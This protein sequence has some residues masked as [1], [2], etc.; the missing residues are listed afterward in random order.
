MNRFKIISLIAGLA[1]VLAL[2]A[3]AAGAPGGKALGHTLRFDVVQFAGDP[4]L[5]VFAGGTAL[6]RD[7]TTGDAVVLTGSGQAKPGQG[8]AA[9]GG[10]FVHRHSNGVL[11]AQGVWIANSV[12]SWEQVDG[13]LVGAGLTDGIGHIDATA[14][15]NLRLNV[16][17]VPDGAGGSLTGVVTIHCQLIGSPETQQEGVSLDV[18]PFHFVPVHDEGFT[19]FHDLG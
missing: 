19:L 6:S 1:V 16:T 3:A 14:A 5:T 9:G 11:V 4:G 12:A 10:T 2:P 17:L 18:G 13:T 7:A 8:D 15:G